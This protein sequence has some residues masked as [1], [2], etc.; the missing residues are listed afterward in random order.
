MPESSFDIELDL[1]KKK[2]WL[3]RCSQCLIIYVAKVSQILYSI[4]SAGSDV[5]CSKTCSEEE[6]RISHSLYASYI[7]LVNMLFNTRVY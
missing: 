2:F 5:V 1:L 6:D 4:K 7:F 3:F